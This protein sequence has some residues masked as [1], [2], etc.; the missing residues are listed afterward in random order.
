MLT[1]MT[2]RPAKPV[3]PAP[4][5]V[6]DPQEA[7]IL[8]RTAPWLVMEAHNRKNSRDFLNHKFNGRKVSIQAFVAACLEHCLYR[9]PAA[10]LPAI[11]AESLRDLERDEPPQPPRVDGG[12]HRITPTYDV[13]PSSGS[14]TRNRA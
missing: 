10:D 14:K 6:P 1:L 3:Q 13:D 9:I 2:K 11:V 5:P 12:R 7:S 8:V 4:E